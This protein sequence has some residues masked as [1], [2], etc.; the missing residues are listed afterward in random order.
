MHTDSALNEILELTGKLVGIEST[1]PGTFETEISEFV[2]AWLEKET[3]IAAVKEYWAPG[4]CNVISVLEGSGAGPEIIVAAHMDTVLVGEGWTK[5]PL[6]CSETEGKLFGRGAADM[7]SG[8]AAAMIAFR[9]M[10]A[11]KSRMRGR[12]IFAATSDEEAGMRGTRELIRRGYIGK[13]TWVLDLDTV[14]EQLVQGHKG[15]C[16]IRV[17]AKGKAA[18]S[19]HPESGAD[20]NLAIAELICDFR[21]RIASCPED[22]IFGKST[23]S[24]GTVRGG[25]GWTSVPERTELCMDVRIA[26]PITVCDVEQML[27][28]SVRAAAG[29]VPGVSIAYEIVESLPWVGIDADAPL[30][31]ALQKAIKTVT[32]ETATPGM[33]GGYTDSGAVA[34]ETGYKNCVSYGAIG[35]NIHAPDE[36]LSIPS[37]EKVYQVLIRFLTDSLL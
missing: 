25:T 19:M 23:V 9:E 7:K 30:V 15:K 4:R 33:I 31:H 34:A 32:G 35:G 22:R 5:A 26:P 36:W 20:T 6:S 17:T 13:D 21:H 37:M 2:S 18:H 28:G 12:L 27:T 3:G 8:L 14:N 16:W 10:S 24:F 1:N 11:Q 29:S